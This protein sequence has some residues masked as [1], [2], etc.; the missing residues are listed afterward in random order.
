MV[1][2]LVLKTD[3]VNTNQHIAPVCAEVTGSNLVEAL[4]FSGFYFPIA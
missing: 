4:V 2:R 1:N 3:N